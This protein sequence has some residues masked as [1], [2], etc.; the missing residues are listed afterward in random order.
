MNVTFKMKTIDKVVLGLGILFVLITNLFQQNGT[1]CLR[2]GERPSFTPIK[3]NQT[4]KTTVF[5][6]SILIFH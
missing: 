1:P 5:I 6:I 3:K 4:G 2:I